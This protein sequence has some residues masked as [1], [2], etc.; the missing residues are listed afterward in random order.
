MVRPT[1]REGAPIAPY[2]HLSDAEKEAIA[3]Q[4]A[5]CGNLAEAARRVV[6]PS[7]VSAVHA[8]ARN[9]P[10]GFGAQVDAAKARHMQS[11]RAEI[12]RRAFGFEKAIVYK[13]E[14]C[15]TV[16]EVSDNL[17]LAYARLFD[18][19]FVDKRT[20]SDIHLSGEINVAEPDRMYIDH[21]E[22]QGLSPEGKAALSLALKEIIK[23]RREVAREQKHFEALT[24]QSGIQDAGFVVVENDDY[25]LA[26]VAKLA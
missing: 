16:T 11:I 23:R 10:L 21:A 20:S 6:G 25:D 7:R 3:E 14:I 9:Q 18:P 1:L 19:L 5:E 2:N 8:C 12:K 15:G 26:E 24:D 13:G 22:V 4:V 17:L